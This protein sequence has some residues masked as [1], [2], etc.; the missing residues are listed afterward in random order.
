MLF[1]F[2]IYHVRLREGMNP[3]FLKPVV[4]SPSLAEQGIK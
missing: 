4:G 3:K 1:Q 2:D